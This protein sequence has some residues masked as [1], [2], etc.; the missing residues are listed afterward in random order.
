M[1]YEHMN[2]NKQWEHMSITQR[3]ELIELM[4]TV[5]NLEG[6]DAYPQCF[7]DLRKWVDC[8]PAEVDGFFSARCQIKKSIKNMEHNIRIL[9]E[10]EL[11]TEDL[12][13]KT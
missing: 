9:R 1:K 5:T 7:I 8:I 2:G 11:I 10:I 3:T 13:E 4:K 6:D 12:K